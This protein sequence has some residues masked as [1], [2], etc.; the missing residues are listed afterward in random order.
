MYVQCNNLTPVF[1]VWGSNQMSLPTS[2]NWKKKCL[3]F[4][5]CTNTCDS[6]LYFNKY[7]QIKI[8]HY[9]TSS[10]CSYFI[11]G[12]L[13]PLFHWLKIHNRSPWLTVVLSFPGT[14]ELTPAAVFSYLLSKISL[15][16]PLRDYSVSSHFV[17]RLF[18]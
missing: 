18:S 10:P 13:L 12:N 6:M 9:S 3:S 4:E 11:Y 14:L 5:C 15:F 2:L 17:L 7:M 8:Y 16:F 1:N